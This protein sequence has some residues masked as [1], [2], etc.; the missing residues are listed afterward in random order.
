M[1][2]LVYKY[3]GGDND[4]FKRDLNSLEENCF[5][6]PNSDKLNDPCETSVFT[7]TFNTQSAFFSK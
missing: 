7:D 1:G 4:I 3:R 6:A 2:K 5:F